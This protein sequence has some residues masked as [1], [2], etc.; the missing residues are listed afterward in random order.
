MAAFAAGFLAWVFLAFQ[1]CCEAL[2]AAV[3]HEH[4]AAHQSALDHSHVSAAAAEESAGDA[5]PRCVPHSLDSVDT[6]YAVAALEAPRSQDRLDPGCDAGPAEAWPSAA[7][8]DLAPRGLLPP[9]GPGSRTYLRFQRF[10][11]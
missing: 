11:E 10:L 2:A 4:P 5:H 3:P 9:R 1:P 7:F 6:V 8:A